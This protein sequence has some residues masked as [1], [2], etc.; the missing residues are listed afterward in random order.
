MIVRDEADNLPRAIRSVA[1]V[2]SQVVVV[3][4]GSRDNTPAVARALGAEVHEAVWRDDFAAARNESLRHIREPW[5]LVLDADEELVADD[6][7]RLAA[8][9]ETPAAEAYNLRI[10]SVVGTGREFADGYVTR[11]FRSDPR[12]RFRGRV[13][14]Q[15]ADS[16]AAVG[17]RLRQLDVRLL[18]TGYLPAVMAARHKH[19]RNL[20]LLRAVVGEEPENPYWHFQLGQTLLAMGRVEESRRA[21]GEALRLLDASSPLL[22]VAIAAAVRAAGAAHDWDAAERLAE[23]GMAAAPEY[24]DLVWLAGLVAMRRH[25]RDQARHHLTRCLALGPPQGFLSS[26]LGVGTFLPKAALAELAQADGRPDEALAWLLAALRDQPRRIATWTAIA[27]LTAGTPPTVLAGHLR[28]VL[29]PAARQDV[30]SNVE[31]L[32]PACRAALEVPE[33]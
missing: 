25:Q 29:G 18:H 3:D 11:L 30:L 14:E 26:E 2:A 27:A 1:A 24:T 16:A 13:H 4:T 33:D 9:V 31:A 15:V 22:P 12:V 17:W 32:P 7:P 19:E 23:S 21:Y 5:V 28:L 6:V 20:A 8:A 10:V